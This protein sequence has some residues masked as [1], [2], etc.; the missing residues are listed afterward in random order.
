MTFNYFSFNPVTKTCIVVDANFY[1]DW[2]YSEVDA[3]YTTYFL[4][5]TGGPGMFVA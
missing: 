4:K 1:D 2:T 3:G 5:E